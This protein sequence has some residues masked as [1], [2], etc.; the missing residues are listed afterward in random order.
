MTTMTLEREEISQIA[1]AL[2]DEK[3]TAAV[4]FMRRLCVESDPF[5]SESNINHLR[6]VRADAEAGLKMSVHELA[7]ADDD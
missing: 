4:E 6:A 1:H 2:P 5:Y 3:V 7:D